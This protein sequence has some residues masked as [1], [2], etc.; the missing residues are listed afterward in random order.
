MIWLTLAIRN[1]AANRRRSAIAI[2]AIAFAATALVLYSGY[3]NEQREGMKF[4]FIH[5]SGTGHIQLS[6]T[7]GFGDFADLPMQFG[8]TPAQRSAIEAAADKISAVRRTVPRLQFGG[9]VSSGPRTL[10]FSGSAIDPAAES[11]AFGAAGAVSAGTPLNRRAPDDGV[12]LGVELARQLGVKPGDDVTIL[13]TTAL[14]SQNAIDMP[15]IGLRST[16]STQGDLYYLQAKLP[17]IQKL[18]LTDKI[19]HLVVLLQD[20]ADFGPL[21]PRLA[22]AAPGIEA[23]DWMQLT[24]IFKQ[25]MGQLEMQ[26]EVV[27]GM[28]IIVTLLGVAVL[29][30]TS[31]LERSREIGVMRSLGITGR[32]VRSVFVLEGLL[33]C[34][35]GVSLGILLGASGSWA[36]NALHLTMP[37]PPGRNTGYPLRLLWDWN[38]P[39]Q[40]TVAVLVFGLGVSWLASG[41]VTRLKIIE[42][43]GAL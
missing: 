14:G 1:I 2:G 42:A 11:S 13:T 20:K 34:V 30:L 4:A 17:T 33:L 32:Q 9:I 41:R 38:A 24:P 29:I 3:I 8:L 39:A 31:V 6:G 35:A 22:A 16:G 43:L 27:G 5:A 37:P 23:R 12:V 19:T 28:L 25:V 10:P 40:V 21:S 26:F 36:I 15:V 18:L 7:G